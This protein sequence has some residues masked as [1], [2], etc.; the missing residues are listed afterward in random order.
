M[1]EIRIIRKVTKNL[2]QEIVDRI[3]KAI[4]PEKII[5]FGSYAYGKPGK[6]SDIDILVI[7]D[8]D[9]ARHKRA[10]LLYNALAGLII[11]K[12]ILV[13][14][15]EEIEE[16]SEVPQAFITTIMR[17]GIVIYEKKKN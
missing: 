5:L 13:Y 4:D 10:S 7:K 17:R 16:W 14:T 2:I 11:P 9:L 15:P 1:E 8:S 3:V 12:D 6:D